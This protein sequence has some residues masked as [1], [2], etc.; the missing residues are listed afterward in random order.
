[1][2]NANKINDIS[3]ILSCSLDSNFL[4]YISFIYRK[5]RITNLQDGYEKSQVAINNFIKVEKKEIKCHCQKTYRPENNTEGCPVLE[6]FW[7]KL[8]NLFGCC[9]LVTVMFNSSGTPWTFACQAPLSMGFP[10]QKYCSGSP[11]P[12]P[13]DLPDPGMELASPA[14]QA[15]S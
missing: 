4:Y 9:C 13:G 11:F 12:S 5:E 7:I 15:D 2:E 1:M 6:K 8:A 3:I 10:R 14:W